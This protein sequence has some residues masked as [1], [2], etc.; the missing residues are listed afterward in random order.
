M[1][2]PEARGTDPDYLRERQYKDPSNL[3]ARIALHAK[4][5]RADVPWF[6]WLVGQVDWP[7]DGRVL[8]VGCG[9]G[10][11]WVST[12]DLLPRLRL[13]LTDLS[14]GMVQAAV[15]AVA[16]LPGIELV[17]SRT[18]DAQDLPYHDDTFD[19]VVADHMLYHVPDPGRAAS[20][21][22][23]VLR[24][25]GV[26]LAATNGPRH[27][28]AVSEVSRAALGWS[29]LDFLDERFGRSTGGEILGTAFRSVTWE[30]HP[31]A[32]VC[33]E[34]AD[35][36]AFIAS[37]AAGR[38]ASPEQRSALHEVVAARFAQE[39]GQMTIATEAGC[40]VAKDPIATRDPRWAD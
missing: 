27:L 1:T 19:V 35:V 25:G 31:S 13:T 36:V 21:F 7:E 2:R 16:R 3:N 40:F 4:Y 15:A 34:P 9:T 5:S 12:A 6:A 30:L 11:L 23:R 32:M 37:T 29:P 10:L 38:D 14:E 8:E 24:P 18:C 26:L 39:G 33:T 17:G 20:E 22:A 28:D